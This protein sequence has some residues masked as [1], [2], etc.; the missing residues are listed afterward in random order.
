[1]ILYARN[2]LNHPKRLSWS[3]KKILLMVQKDFINRQ[4]LKYYRIFWKIKKE[5][6][7]TITVQIFLKTPS[8]LASSRY[9]R[10][11]P[12]ME[13]F[14]TWLTCFNQT[15]CQTM[16]AFNYTIIRLITLGCQYS[17]Y[18]QSK[19]TF[20]EFPDTTG[21]KSVFRP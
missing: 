13:L 17:N 4:T 20:S 14:T 9:F 5:K 18:E 11:C 15:P 2:F 10:P 21:L 16:A 8:P 3:S 12:A 7:K 6:S 1:M 19:F